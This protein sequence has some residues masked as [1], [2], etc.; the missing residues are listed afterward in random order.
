MNGF[1]RLAILFLL[2]CG[3]YRGNC[4][5]KDT[6]WY[7]RFFETVDRDSATYYRT[8]IERAGDSFL[9]RYYHPNHKLAIEW[10]TPD[11]DTV[12]REGRFVYFDTAARKFAEGYRRRGMWTGVRMD[13]FV[14]TGRPARSTFYV[15]DIPNGPCVYYDSLSGLPF[16]SGE[17]AEGLRTGKWTYNYRGSPQVFSTEN[18]KNGW[19]D[20]ETK[21]YYPSGRLRRREM[22]KAG[23][24][25]NAAVFSNTGKKT[26]YVPILAPPKYKKRDLDWYVEHHLQKLPEFKNEDKVQAGGLVL[27]FDIK[28][29]G[30]VENIGVRN[31][32]KPTIDAAFRKAIE[33]TAWSPAM[34]EGRPIASH[35]TIAQLWGEDVTRKMKFDYGKSY[36]PTVDFEF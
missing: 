24:S 29:D 15:H 20:G 6:V 22:F 35:V 12:V 11:G 21:S 36:P 17:L 2:V 34:L 3:A 23:K 31:S 27:E 32:W 33:E 7:G 30:T 18:F 1:K 25:V 19:L 9:Y 13:Y 26:K 28:A 16:Y 8:I 5:S 4:Q 10:H 14:S